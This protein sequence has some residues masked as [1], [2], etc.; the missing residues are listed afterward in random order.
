MEVVQGD[1]YTI[2]MGASKV[3]ADGT[4]T[5]D[6]DKKAELEAEANKPYPSPEQQMIAALVAKV[7]ELEAKDERL[8]NGE[9]A[10]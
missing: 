5:I 1:L 6:D 9:T 10:V 7:T 2:I 8:R 4:I 3:S